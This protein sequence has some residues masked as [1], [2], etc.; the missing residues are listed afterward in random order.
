M[1][2][3]YKNTKFSKA[4]IGCNARFSYTLLMD[5]PEGHF[6]TIKFV[7]SIVF[8]SIFTP[9]TSSLRQTHAPFKTIAASTTAAL[10]KVMD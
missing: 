3:F 5:A 7:L 8:I 10:W 9:E 6:S 2:N 1:L 4:A